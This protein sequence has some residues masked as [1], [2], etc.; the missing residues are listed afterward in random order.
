MI[1]TIY[2]ITNK[3]NAKQYIGMTNNISKRWREHIKADGGCPA[4]HAAIHKY[5]IGSFVLTVIAN[6]YDRES[7]CSVE[8]L[9]I[10]EH[11]TKSPHGYNIARG[12][13]GGIGR[14]WTPE[15]RNTRNFGMRGKKHTDASK[16]KN[17]KSNTGNRIGWRHTEE[18]KAKMSASKIGK[19]N[20]G[21]SPET[22]AKMSAVKM[23]KNGWRH[24]DE[25]RAKMTAAH[26][27]R[28]AKMI[29]EKEKQ[30]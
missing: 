22:K 1:Y 4:L 6:S 29:S 23:G 2:I 7:A 10:A 25:A 12:G 9:L 21:H 16:E 28:K 19:S 17:R 11:N 14:P 24:T 5:G 15:E 18:S 20:G 30:K 3:V 27:I 26:V 13:E 8:R